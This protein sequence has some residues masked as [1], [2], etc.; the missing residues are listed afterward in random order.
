VAENPWALLGNNDSP[1]SANE[2]T[3]EEATA[4]IAAE[5]VP[6][7]GPPPSSPSPDIEDEGDFEEA[8]PEEEAP[9]QLPPDDP[10]RE[11]LTNR[12]EEILR[13]ARCSSELREGVL[14]CPQCGRQLHPQPEEEAARQSTLAA[15]LEAEIGIQLQWATRLH[16][17]PFVSRAR[18]LRKALHDYDRKGLA[19]RMIAGERVTFASYEDRYRR[20][21]QFR[22]NMKGCRPPRD[23]N[24]RALV[25]S[26]E[27]VEKP[28]DQWTRDLAE[29]E[30]KQAKKGE[31]KGKG[32]P[33]ARENKGKGKGQGPQT[34][35]EPPR[36]PTQRQRDAQQGR[37]Q[38]GWTAAAWW[39]A[40]QWNTADATSVVIYE[41][42]AGGNTKLFYIF[43]LILFTI[44]AYYVYKILSTI[45]KIVK[46]F[47]EV[48]FKYRSVG[49]QSQCTY[50]LN[51]NRFKA[52]ENGFR[53]SGEVEIDL[54]E[55]FKQ[56]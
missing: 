31:G 56:E 48:K 36:P 54:H 19:G 3:A 30:A 11:Q 17:T 39:T 47:Y 40:S 7:D 18:R 38:G 49:V 6:G 32:K 2:A 42:K 51:V 55:H 12:P 44:A 10:L 8:E 13:C 52:Y 26:L 28:R 46:S 53:R 29:R 43:G 37:W 22:N 24:F 16:R 50:D 35:P 20:D 45:N 21:E 1:K 27:R 33:Y 9:V 14:I 23:L 5:A 4:D 15:E 25:E 41:E 34:P